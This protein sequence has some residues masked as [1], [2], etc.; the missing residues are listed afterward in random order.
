[1][2]VS[3]G[4]TKPNGHTESLL[5]TANSEHQPKEEA[6]NMSKSYNKNAPRRYS[7]RYASGTL[8]P[9]P[10]WLPTALRKFRRE[11]SM[12]PSA[13]AR[14]IP[15]DHKGIR[16]SAHAVSNLMNNDLGR[17]KVQERVGATLLGHLTTIIKTKLPGPEGVIFSEDTQE[18]E[19]GGERRGKVLSVSQLVTLY[20]TL[21]D[22]ADRAIVTAMV[23]RLQPIPQ[24][25]DPRVGAIEALLD[26][27]AKLEHEITGQPKA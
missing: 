9:I 6:Q 13:I 2:S 17:A 26:V 1:M 4:H 21:A 15:K 11:T 14:L 20:A 18:I 19:F 5:K 7:G 25:E 23:D 22:D 3:I 27:A 12:S 10:E 24:P 8:V 16:V